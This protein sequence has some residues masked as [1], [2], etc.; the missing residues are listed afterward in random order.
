M[1][2]FSTQDDFKI[3]L[4]VKLSDKNG[5]MVPFPKGFYKLTTRSGSSIDNIEFTMNNVVNINTI[6]QVKNNSDILEN[7]VITIEPKITDDSGNIN[8]KDVIPNSFTFDVS[9]NQNTYILDSAASLKAENELKTSSNEKVSTQFLNK[10]DDNG[11]LN[12]TALG[13]IYDTNKKKIGDVSQD[14]MDTNNEKSFNIKVNVPTNP[15]D[16]LK[17]YIKKMIITFKYPVPTASKTGMPKPPP[18]IPQGI[19]DSIPAPNPDYSKN[20]V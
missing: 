14:S 3:A 15:D 19:V 1:E 17:S 9:F 13:A 20:K 6:S 8:I 2:K 11:T 12:I 18:P 10:I 7:R 16:L 5:R 4:N